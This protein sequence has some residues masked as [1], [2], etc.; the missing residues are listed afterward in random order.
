VV[1]KRHLRFAFGGGAVLLKLLSGGSQ[2][3]IWVMGN[4]SNLN[5][6]IEVKH[7]ALPS[8]PIAQITPGTVGSLAAT[9]LLGGAR[10]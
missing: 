9:H 7:S 6:V 3:V 2:G 10:Q 5:G 8:L 4:E 1:D